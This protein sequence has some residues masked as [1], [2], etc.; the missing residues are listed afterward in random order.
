MYILPNPHYCDPCV[1]R[2]LLPS[3]ESPVTVH[4]EKVD[5]FEADSLLGDYNG[6]SFSSLG[7]YRAEQLPLKDA[8]TICHEL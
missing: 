3:S 7:L 8:K 2:I 6:I 1:T 5:K 4:L